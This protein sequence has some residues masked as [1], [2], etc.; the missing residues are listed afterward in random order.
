M[1]PFAVY[2]LARRSSEFPLQL[3]KVQASN[4]NVSNVARRVTDYE[5]AKSNLYYRTFVAFDGGCVSGWA[6]CDI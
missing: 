6:M 2:R 5:D 4:S 3:V 1:K